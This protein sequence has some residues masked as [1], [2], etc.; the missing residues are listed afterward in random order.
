MP[1]PKPMPGVGW[2]PELLG[3]PVVA[4]SAADGVLRALEGVGDEL[5]GRARVVVE[6]AHE[7]RR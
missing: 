2:P 5:E 3:E 4:P 7:P 1:M 6:A